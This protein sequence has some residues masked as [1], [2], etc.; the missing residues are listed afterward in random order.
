MQAARPVTRRPLQ[1]SGQRAPCAALGALTLALVLGACAVDVPR[2]E[3]GPGAGGQSRY[4]LQPAKGPLAMSEEVS[5][6]R[7]YPAQVAL[8]L[9]LSGRLGDAGEALRDG[10]LAAWFGQDALARPRL[11]IYDSATDA[12]RAYAQALADGAGFVVGPLGKESVEAVVR[13][14]DGGVPTLALNFLPDGAVVP[15]RFYQFALA[16]EDEARQVAERLLAEGRSTGIA[17][18]PTGDWGARVL[19]AFG[20]TLTAG[21]GTL[22]AA[23]SY[24][25]AT[26]DYSEL[27]VQVLGFDQSRARHREVVAAVGTPLEFTPRRRADLT[28]VFVAGQPTQGRLLRSQLRFHYAGDLPVLSLSDIYDPNPAAN[29]DLDGVVFAD[30]PWMISDDPTVAALRNE[31][32]QLWPQD[33]RRRGRLFAMG[34]DCYALVGA[35]GPA[36]APVAEPIAGMS[37]RLTLDA[38]GRVHRGLDWAVFGSDGEVRELPPVTGTAA[39]PR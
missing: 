18:V 13:A 24:P 12:A 11:R 38:G 20:A 23:R 39:A 2:P 25:T 36:R 26:H 6:S 34:Y 17:L 5:P 30:S 31:V 29:Q 16:P 22:T 21:G 4:P 10:F 15:P 37:G 35:L 19:T 14:A 8:L 7:P 28:F 33:A 3:T 9:P 27:L 1:P 32:A